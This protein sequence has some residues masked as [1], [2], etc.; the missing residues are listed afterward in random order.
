MTLYTRASHPIYNLLP[1]EI[2]GFNALA[3]LALDLRWSWSHATDHVRRQLDPAL[4]DLTQ[5]PWVVLQSVSGD[6]IER[7]FDDPVFRKNWDDVGQ[8]RRHAMEAPAW[9]AN[10]RSNTTLP[11]AA[12]YR[13]RAADNGTAGRRVIDWKQA[14]KEKWLRLGFGDM[15]VQTNEAQHI[16]EAE[17]YLNDLDPKTVRVELSA[18]GINGSDPIRREMTR[19]RP[20]V[21]E[22]RGGIYRASVSAA[23]FVTDFTDAS[24]PAAAAR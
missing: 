3:E 24:S 16:F 4:W 14:L 6:Q 20:L 19:V 9:R 15:K 23:R 7:V 11:A 5:K 22:S 17:V 12:A 21:C 18:D 8:A 13:T 2:K 10:T 1:T